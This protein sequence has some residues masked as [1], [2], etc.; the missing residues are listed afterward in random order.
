MERGADIHNKAEDYLKGKLTKLPVE[1]KLF[2]GLFKEL[3]KQYKKKISG[4]TVEDTWALTKD[5]AQTTWN[6]WTGC[7]IRIKLDC[8]HHLDDEHLIISDWKTGKFRPELNEEY[9]EQLELYALGALILHPHVKVVEPRLVYLD[10]GKTYPSGSGGETITYDRSDINELKKTWEKRVK[11]MM[12]D[13]RFAPRPN[14]KCKWC[15]FSASKG[16]PCKF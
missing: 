12:N 14:D 6:D 13:T 16:G 1:L 11:P 7:W 4:M 15:H 9:M 8:A 5:W 2:E 3:K 10:E